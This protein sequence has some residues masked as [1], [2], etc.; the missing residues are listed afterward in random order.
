MLLGPG[1]TLDLVH[2]DFA[3]DAPPI[4]FSRDETY[5]Q[6]LL[7]R[8]AVGLDDQNRLFLAAIDG[9]NFD[10]APG[11]TLRMTADLMRALGCVRAMNLD[12]GSSKR[13]AVGS[14]CVDLASTEVVSKQT[15][16]SKKRT[17][18]SAIL[19]YCPPVTT[20]ELA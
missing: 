7:P 20:P 19:L 8:M 18:V 6:N 13:M 4:T 15:E 1:P 5:D 17:V 11:F 3:W 16:P 14:R 12:G 10:R 2:E 9:R